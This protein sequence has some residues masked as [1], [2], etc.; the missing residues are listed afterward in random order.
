MQNFGT[1]GP[2]AEEEVSELSTRAELEPVDGGEIY[3]ADAAVGERS[4][5]LLGCPVI[6]RSPS[7]Q[8]VTLARHRAKVAGARE[9][10]AVDDEGAA[11]Y[12]VRCSGGVPPR[13]EPDRSRAGS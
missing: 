1:F 4:D 7:S 5:F 10:G 13:R 6:D 8:S 3:G 9:E 12:A 11:G 2:Q